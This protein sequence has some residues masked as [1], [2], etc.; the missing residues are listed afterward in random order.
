MVV[1]L[2]AG[3]FFGFTTFFFATFALGFFAAAFF[4][5]VF[6]VVDFLTAAFFLVDFSD[7][8]GSKRAP[9]TEKARVAGTRR[10]E[11]ATREM[12][13]VLRAILFVEA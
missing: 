10:I 9:Y 1:F 5:G 6:F 13:G 12:V 8:A 2:G 4:T 7:V 11:S 3:F